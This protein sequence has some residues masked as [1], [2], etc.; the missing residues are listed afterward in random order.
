MSWEDIFLRSTH[1]RL[2]WFDENL[3]PNVQSVIFFISFRSSIQSIADHIFDGFLY[4][5]SIS[6]EQQKSKSLAMIFRPYFFAQIQKKIQNLSSMI[7]LPFLSKKVTE[8]CRNFE[9]HHKK[10]RSNINFSV[11]GELKEKVNFWMTKFT[12]WWMTNK[13]K[14]TKRHICGGFTPIIHVWHSSECSILALFTSKSS[15]T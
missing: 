6:E 1:K 13:N 8:S 12:L 11:W 9:N 2:I 5:K 14:K 15:S 3:K 4:N 10:T 7:L